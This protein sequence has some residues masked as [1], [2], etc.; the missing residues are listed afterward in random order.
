MEFRLHSKFI[1]ALKEMPFYNCRYIYSFLRNWRLTIYNYSKKFMKS[2][3]FLSLLV[4][5]LVLLIACERRGRK[6]GGVDAPESGSEVV[7][8]E[9]ATVV[10][11]VNVAAVAPK[12]AGELDGKALFAAN[13]SACHQIAGT[14]V[15]GAFPPLV[16]SPYVLSDNVERMASIMIYGLQ[17]P[18]NV[19]GTTYASIMAPLGAT[20]KDE[21]L[22]AIATY[23]R[24]AW[25]NTASPIKTDVFAA[26]RQKWGSRSFFQI[27]EL[28]EEK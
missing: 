14:G 22:A 6:F 26:M 27:S 12:V 8:P 21:E 3:L 2:K 1:P 17:G 15:P 10:A 16:N 7:A 5:L 4:A 24:S 19:L 18:I 28:G 25:G 9:S 20:L 11:E 13:C 23:V